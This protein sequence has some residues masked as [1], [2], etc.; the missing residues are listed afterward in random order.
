M[1]VT[2]RVVLIA[3]SVLTLWYTAR[4]IRKSQMQ[5][6]DAIFW[7]G[8]PAVLVVLSVAPGLA[9]WAAGILGIQS[10]VNFI[11]L[12]IIFVLILKIFSLS[13]RFSQ[14][15]TKI[16]TLTQEIAIRERLEKDE[17]IKGETQVG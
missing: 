4:K 8:F 12:S 15:D 7:I 13:I 5:I 16:R 14:M 9:S 17:K 6:E 10:A 1:S 2:F 11:Y 3:V